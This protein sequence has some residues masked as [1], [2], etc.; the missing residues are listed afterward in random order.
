MSMNIDLEM[1]REIAISSTGSFPSSLVDETFGRCACFMIWNPYTEVY[2]ELFNTENE[3]EYAAGTGA[4]YT[5]VKNHVGLVISERVGPKAFV[6]LKQAGIKIFSG[7][8]GKTVEEAVQS[9]EAGELQ[10]LLSPNNEHK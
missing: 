2:S 7:I 5:L 9:Y 4:V 8:A 1:S 10:E 6:L 3:A